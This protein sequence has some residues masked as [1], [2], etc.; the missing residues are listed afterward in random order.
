MHILNILIGVLWLNVIDKIF[1]IL[2]SKRYAKKCNYN[3]ENCGMWSCVNETDYD[4]GNYFI[5]IYDNYKNVCGK[6]NLK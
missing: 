2:V 6:E 1:G 5:G 4:N 3:C